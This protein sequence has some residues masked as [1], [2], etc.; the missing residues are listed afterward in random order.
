MPEYLAIIP[1][2][3]GS[4]RLPNKNLLELGGIPLIGWTIRAALG[5]QFISEI[6]VTSDSDEVLNYSASLG[7]R[8]QHKRDSYL[9]A[10]D[11]SSIDVVLDVLDNYEAK[12]IIFLQPTSPLRTSLHIDNA[13]KLFKSI[14]ANI[15]SICK[16]SPNLDLKFPVHFNSSTLEITF[17]T[18][19]SQFVCEHQLNGAIYIISAKKFKAERAFIDQKTCGFMMDHNHSIDIDFYEDLQVA[20]NLLKK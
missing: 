2:R 13:V 11:A 8:Y 17:Q 9:A 5:S 6:V 15:V 20:R 10:D 14:D 18:S 16:S 19:D 12:N 1:A 3:K 4:K 7:I